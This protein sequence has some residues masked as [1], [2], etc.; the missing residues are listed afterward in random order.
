MQAYQYALPKMP[1]LPEERVCRQAPFKSIGID[2]LGP[3]ETRLA[4]EKVKAWIL[5]MTCLVTRAVHLEAM[6]D[7]TAE[8][9][10]NVLRRFISR[11]GKPDLIWS[12]NATS[13]KLA[14]KTISLLTKPGPGQNS[15]EFLALNKIKWRFIAQISPWAGGFYERLV[16]LCKNCFKRIGEENPQLRPAH[17]IC[18]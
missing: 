3:T 1:P 16:Q 15:E 11:R 9:F 2:F 12:D 10:L 14:E 8:S 7:T 13:F 5:L 17:H 18:G 6:L 4:G